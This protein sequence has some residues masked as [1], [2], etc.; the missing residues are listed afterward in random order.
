MIEEVER[1]VE[2]IYARMSFTPEYRAKLERW[3]LDEIHKSTDKMAVERK[4]MEAKKDKLE[5]KQKKL[6]EAYYADSLPLNLFKAE[7]KQ[8]EDALAAI[9]RRIKLQVENSAEIEERLHLSL[10][11]MEDC[12]KLYAAA[13]D[14]I[15]R[16]YNQAI[17]EKIYINRNENDITAIPVFAETYALLFNQ[18]SEKNDGAKTAQEKESGSPFNVGAVSLAWYL[19]PENQNTAIVHHE[20]TKK[21]LCRIHLTPHTIVECGV[22]LAILICKK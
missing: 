4:E 12:G 6:L 11:L 22:A 1:Q 5:R 17:F 8:L 10:D 21:S 9:D 7:Q 16:A 13:S 15:K 2:N 14:Y 20:A 3:I 19:P 18:K